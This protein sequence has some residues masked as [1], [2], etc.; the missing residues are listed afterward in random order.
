M[1]FGQFEI[2]NRKQRRLRL[3]INDN[4]AFYKKTYNKIEK[5]V[6][7]EFHDLREKLVIHL[8]LQHS[9]GKLEQQQT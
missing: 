6:I 9:E 2:R 3:G 7:N 5:K 1:G 4:N 8:N